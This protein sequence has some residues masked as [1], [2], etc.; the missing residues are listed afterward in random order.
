[1]QNIV[2]ISNLTIWSTKRLMPFWGFSDNLLQDAHN[3]FQRSV[4]NFEIVHKMPSILV[5]DSVPP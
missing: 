5:W 1:M 3:S 4:D 2:L